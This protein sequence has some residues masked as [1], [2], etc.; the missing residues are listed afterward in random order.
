[1][2]RKQQ[3]VIPVLVAIAACALWIQLR[4][5]PRVYA[6]IPPPRQ[7][8]TAPGAFRLRTNTVI[9][10]DGEFRETAETLAKILGRSAG[11]T[12]KILDPTTGGVQAPGNSIR[13]FRPSSAPFRSTNTEAYHLAVSVDSVRVTASHQAG[14][15]HGVRTLLQLLPPEV[16]GDLPPAGSD[17]PW[18]I[19][20]LEVTDEPMFPW[21]GL[22]L[23]VA[24][25]Y[26]SPAEIRKSLDGLALHKLNR[27]H[28]HLT[29]DQ[30]WR[31]AI[32]QYPRL[33]EVGAWREGIGFG[34]DPAASSHY[35][36]D[37]RYGGFYSQE[38]IT[39]LVRYA[40]SQQIMIVPEI[41]MPGHATAALAAYP[42]LGCSG[43]EHATEL[44]A[45]VFTSVFCAGKEE[46][47]TFLETVLTE[48]IALFPGEYI[49]VGGDEVPKR[50]W[51]RCP[52]CQAR[53]QAENLKD[54]E[55]LQT[56]FLNRIETFLRSKGRRMIGWSEILDRQL[57]TN[58]IVMDWIGGG[59][60]AASQGLNVIMSPVKHAYLDYYQST[61][62]A[63]EPRAVG[64]YL[65]LERVYGFEPIPEGVLPEHERLILGGQGNLWTEY[66]PNQAQAEYMLYPRLCAI[67]E[68]LWAPAKTRNFSQFK[69]DMTTH[70][71]RL[72]AMR[73]QYR[74]LDP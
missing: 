7:M 62:R 37:G 48:T 56:W 42:E 28:L 38:E 40:T 72:D 54:E 39:E 5:P 47:F 41:E 29:D 73:I 12:P 24:R 53:M 25:H 17:Q 60:Q 2:N 69:R 31:L 36:P 35:R 64:G 46:T 55:E 61:N 70:F 51:R 30:G 59:A 14:M 20:C 15:L 18:L 45:G 13:L 44:S 49:H 6:L 10:A 65:P 58:A 34:L 66:I 21:R 22:M 74:P 43:T 52:R 33:T 8:E 1:M 63:N 16:F 32:N 50:A 3:L 4:P 26:F 68:V 19:P 57:S 71:K 9:L 11:I 27:L 67:S 23:D